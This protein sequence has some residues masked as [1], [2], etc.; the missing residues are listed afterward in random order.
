MNDIKCGLSKETFMT[1]K[2]TT[3]AL[4]GLA[5]YL[6]EDKGFEYVPL[7]LVSSDPLEKRFGWYRQ[8]GG[9]NYYI[10]VRQFLE[11][12][13]K[14]RLQS[15]VKFGK[16]TFKEACELLKPDERSEDTE[17]EAKKLMEMLGDFEIE[18]RVN[19][20]EAIL[21][22]IAGFLAC[23]EVKGLSCEKCT[24][25][26]AKSKNTP[27]IDFSDDLGDKKEEF[28]KQINRGGLFTPSDAMYILVLFARQLFKQ[29]FD[30]ME[31]QDYF[32][33]LKSQREVY[34]EC[35]VLKLQSDKSTAAILEQECENSHK[36]SEHINSIGHRV[37]NTLSKNFVEEIKSK[38]HED[39]KR[40]PKGDPKTDPTARKVLKLTCQ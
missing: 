1:M 23:S 29:I 30:R 14:I 39:K 22:Y 37:F 7:G 32:M 26:F 34:K 17:K 3:D 35:F 28:L 38:I 36:F 13:K 2:Q 11:A 8:L 31:K 24:P 12:E 10:S 5:M 4:C 16:F 40:K 19:D 20:E 9:A 15:L 21:F 25:L 27:I 33:S 18:F 6:L